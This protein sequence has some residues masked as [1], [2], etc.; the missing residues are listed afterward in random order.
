MLADRCVNIV[1]NFVGRK[2]TLQ[3]KTMVS[4]G[5]GFNRELRPKD[6]IDV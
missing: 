5:V 2:C 6:A 1:G 4:Q 3:R